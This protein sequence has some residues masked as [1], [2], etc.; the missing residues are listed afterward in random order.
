M[1]QN[2]PLQSICELLQ[3][4]FDGLYMGDTQILSRIFHPDALYVCASSQ[5]QFSLNMPSYFARV[6]ER[7]SP[8]SLKQSR[9]DRILSIDILDSHIATAK[10]QCALPPK[11]FID[12]LTLI[13]TTNG[14][15]IISKVFNYSLMDA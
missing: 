10:V 7:P 6:E 9:Y 11:L 4:Y 8:H 14:W 13:N 12:S 1:C 3:A 2:T 15:Q 5:Q